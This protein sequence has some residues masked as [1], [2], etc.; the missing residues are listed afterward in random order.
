MLFASCAVVKKDPPLKK[1]YDLSKKAIKQ[2][3]K[4]NYQRSIDYLEKVARIMEERNLTHDDVYP[5]TYAKIGDNLTEMGKYAEAREMYM[6]AFNLTNDSN[7]Y[8]MYDYFPSINDLYHKISVHDS[9]LFDT[10]MS[11]DRS[12]SKMYLP[13]DTMI[14][15]GKYTGTIKLAVTSAQSYKDQVISLYKMMNEG[16]QVWLHKLGEGK[17]VKTDKEYTYYDYTAFD[18][19]APINFQGGRHF[20][21]AESFIPLNKNDQLAKMYLNGIRF[22]G[23]FGQNIMG[24]KTIITKDFPFYRNHLIDVYISSLDDVEGAFT[25]STRS[26][27]TYVMQTGYYRGKMVWDL[28]CEPSHDDIYRYIRYC[29]DNNLSYMESVEYFPRYYIGWLMNDA[30]MSVEHVHDELVALRDSNQLDFTRYDDLIQAT[31]WTTFAE[32]EVK[33]LREDGNFLRALKQ[34]ELLQKYAEFKQNDSLIA[35]SR[36]VQGELYIDIGHRNN[37]TN[38]LNQALG[39]FKDSKDEVSLARTK[40][41]L[42]EVEDPKS[43]EVMVQANHQTHFYMALHP[44]GK[45]FY[46]AGWDG[47]VKK[48]DL[49]TERVVINLKS[50]HDFLQDIKVSA[51]GKYVVTFDQNGKIVV[52]ESYGLNTIKVMQPA[53][54][55]TDIDIS[56]DGKW[57]GYLTGDSI[58]YLL[59]WQNSEKPIELVEHKKQVSAITFD[60]SKNFVWTGGRDSLICHWNLETK[61][62]KTRY[63]ETA[64]VYSIGVSPNGVFMACVTH[65]TNVALWSTY[66]TKRIGKVKTSFDRV[67]DNI[68]FATPTFSHDN[69]YM[70]MISQSGAFMMVALSERRFRSFRNVHNTMVVQLQYHPVQRILFALDMDYRIKKLDVRNYRPK[71][72]KSIP[73]ELI[74]NRSTMLYRTEI[75]QDN[76]AILNICIGETTD[77]YRYDLSTGGGE[78]LLKGVSS[79]Q[80]E[81]TAGNSLVTYSDHLYLDNEKGEFELLQKMPYELEPYALDLM[82]GMMYGIKDDRYLVKFDLEK[83]DSVYQVPL[84]DSMMVGLNIERLR[85]LPDLNQ[86]LVQPRNSSLHFVD[87]KTGEFS[88]N[89][90][91]IFSESPHQFEIDRTNSV[92]AMYHNHQ[93]NAYDL[94]RGEFVFKKDLNEQGNDGFASALAV[95]PE[96]NLIAYGNKNFQAVVQNYLT[97]DTIFISEPFS[98]YIFRLNFFNDKPLLS[99]TSIGNSVELVN[100]EKGRRLLDIY[101]RRNGTYITMIDSGYYWAP[102]TALNSITFKDGRRV[103][104]VESFDHIFNRPDKVLEKSPFVSP[105]YLQ[106]IS[107]AVQKRTKGK[108]RYRDLKNLPTILIKNLY[109]IDEQVNQELLKVL[110]QATD[111][112]NNVSRIYITVN[113][114]PALGVNGFEVKPVQQLEQEINVILNEGNNRVAIW[115]ENTEGITSLKENILVNYSPTSETKADLYLVALSVSSY[116]DSTYDLRYAAKDGQDFV[117]SFDSARSKYRNVYVDTLFNENAIKENLSKVADRLSYSRPND[118]IVVFVSGHGLLDKN[119]DFYFASHDCDFNNPEKRGI[120]YSAIEGLFDNASARQRILL[121]DAC[122]SGEVD[123]DEIIATTNVIGTEGSKGIISY[124]YKGA[125]TKKTADQVGLENSFELMKE[126]FADIGSKGIQVISAA[127]GNSYALESDIWGNGVFTASILEAIQSNDADYND[128]GEISVSELRT[129]VTEEVYRLTKGKQRPTVRNENIEYDFSVW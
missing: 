56:P 43:I 30:P 34:A 29:N 32:N 63:F 19:T 88:T 71:T 124:S 14:V 128:D 23:T 67:L 72:S 59:D 122:H 96:K 121:I 80:N 119:F 74:E 78:V 126:L 27:N 68:Y 49:K 117:N 51:N 61:K 11:E 3:K 65:D 26:F 31:D 58:A 36:L 44:N 45:Y 104:P 70:S 50:Q 105:L 91:L 111:F 5:T 82:R 110:V 21:Y 46:T 95:Y 127:A 73:T 41:I 28:I 113:G 69:L 53:D 93:I 120:P 101:P 22:T 92:C 60:P 25:D 84:P 55:M 16:G 114:V 89:R 94:T 118:K 35:T 40:Q 13:I 39:Y 99:I 115:C 24:Y 125:S 106:A 15:T 86:V 66:E 1:P 123:K 7:V 17:E 103:Y 6:H 47:M 109:A 100:Y 129:F 57:I 33:G 9:L 116:A 87:C 107:H 52:Y 83:E 2:F 90:D 81:I 62:I 54:Y 12:F 79:I 76:T 38:L 108:N 48:W 20:V 77:L 64:K 10:L 18:S 85:F 42:D 75:S 8:Y 4:G 97:G 112:Q 37:A 98:W 102:K